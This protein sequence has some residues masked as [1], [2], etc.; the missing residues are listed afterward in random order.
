MLHP[1]AD[2]VDDDPIAAL[3]AGRYVDRSTSQPARIAT[4]SIV[5]EESLAGREADLVAALGMGKRIGVVSDKDTHTVLGARIE[6]ALAGRFEV[7]S[8]SL[9]AAPHADDDNVARIRAASAS[10]DALIAVG[11]GTINDLAK[12][13]SA[14]DGKPYAVFGTAPSMNGYTSLTASISQHGHKLTLPAHAPLGAFFDLSVLAAAPKRMI[15]AGV[16]DSICRATAQTDWLLSHLLLGTS[17][18]DLPFDLLAD[19]EPQLLDVAADLV[20]GSRDAMRILVRTLILSGLG[21]AIVG[22]SAPASQAEHLISHYI[23]MLAPVTRPSV[24]HGEQVGVTTLSAARLQEEMLAS[25]PRFAPNSVSEAELVAHFGKDL[26]DSVAPEIAAKAI[27]SVKA[28][29]LNHRIERDWPAIASRLAAIHLS[30][31]RI[32]AVLHATG[33]PLTPGAIHLERDFYEAAILHAR[34][35][36]NRFTVLDVLASGGR[37]AKLIPTV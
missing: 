23:D 22:S 5:I 37:L 33:A 6:S 27:D 1:E 30:P 24:F 36:R 9:P 12:Y 26:A 10:L 20:A 25:P 19:E 31:S 16:G 28:D 35:I 18:S 13:A 4:R 17:Y 7:A 29:E 2:Q 15:R 3:V 14:L 21:T 34:E 32:E 11:S 8:I